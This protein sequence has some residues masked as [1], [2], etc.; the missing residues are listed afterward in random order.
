MKAVVGNNSANGAPLCRGHPERGVTPGVETI[1][2][3]V[4]NRQPVR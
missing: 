4:G 1:S 3:P 2:G